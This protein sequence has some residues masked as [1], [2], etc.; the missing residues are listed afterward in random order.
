MVLPDPSAAESALE[1]VEDLS[2]H[3]ILA[4]MELG[5]ELETSPS[6][7]VPLDRY[8]KRAFAIDEASEVSI[9]PFLLIVRTDRIVTV[10]R[11]NLRRGCDSERVPSDTRSFQHIAEFIDSAFIHCLTTF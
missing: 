3:R 6:A 4:D 11:H 2:P 10:H 8:M 9:Q 7:R 1:E 5:H